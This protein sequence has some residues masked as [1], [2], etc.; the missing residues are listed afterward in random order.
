M[1]AA[2]RTK[3]ATSEVRAKS[4][5][6]LTRLS[7]GIDDGSPSDLPISEGT[8]RPIDPIRILVQA[9]NQ[10]RDA[11]QRRGRLELFPRAF[12]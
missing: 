3:D 5:I 1:P 9:A 7:A 4:M 8:M 11:P 6:F 10:C 12:T 2:L